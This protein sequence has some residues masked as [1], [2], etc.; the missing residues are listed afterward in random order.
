[1]QLLEQGTIDNLSDEIGEYDPKYKNAQPEPCADIPI[2][3]EHLLAHQSGVPHL[4]TLW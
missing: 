1:M 2:T 3:F 4:T